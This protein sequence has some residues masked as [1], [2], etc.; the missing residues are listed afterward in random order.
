MKRGKV[1]GK[2]G[3]QMHKTSL[4]R[5]VIDII[6]RQVNWQ[7][8]KLS[9]TW[10]KKNRI[11]KEFGIGSIKFVMCNHSFGNRKKLDETFITK[12]NAYREFYI[13]TQ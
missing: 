7:N 3:K 8:E 6:K 12:R 2:G 1:G 13:K 4:H 10:I 11:L 5:A 9:H